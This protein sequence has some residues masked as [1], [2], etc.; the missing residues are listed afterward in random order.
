MFMKNFVKVIEYDLAPSFL[1]YFTLMGLGQFFVAAAVFAYLT[2]LMGVV[3]FI[4]YQKN[5]VKLVLIARIFLVIFTI[6]G[7]FN[8]FI[9]NMVFTDNM[10]DYLDKFAHGGVN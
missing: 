4:A 10:P 2:L 7:F 8:I 1:I 5:L 6:A 3:L 9:D